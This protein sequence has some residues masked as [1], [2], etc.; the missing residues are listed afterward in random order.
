ME[1]REFVNSQILQNEYNDLNDALMGGPSNLANSNFTFKEKRSQS[2]RFSARSKY[3]LL[4]TEII[5]AINIELEKEKEKWLLG[6]ERHCRRS[7]ITL[8]QDGRED[9]FCA[10]GKL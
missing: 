5:N 9:H 2:R 1:Y 6:V 3:T 4:N 7:F 10:H 8:H